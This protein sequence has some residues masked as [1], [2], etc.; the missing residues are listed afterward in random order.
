MLLI[1]VLL[2]IVASI[3]LTAL[4]QKSRPLGYQKRTA[5]DSSLASLTMMWSG[6]LLAVFI[7]Y[8]VLHFELG[9]VHLNYQH[10]RV[11]DNVIAG[12]RVIPGAIGY[13]LPMILLGMTLNNGLAE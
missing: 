3:Q 9:V 8:H 2:H 12:Y 7:V 13:I 10:G 5:I 6:P 4:N 11:Y 1:S